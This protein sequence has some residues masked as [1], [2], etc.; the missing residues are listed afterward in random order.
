M[1]DELDKNWKDHLAMVTKLAG[2]LMPVIGGPLSELIV[3]TI[4]R[5]RQERIVEY[6]RLLDERVIKLE[7]TSIAVVL[8]DE[9]RIDLVETGGHLAAR[10]TSFDRIAMI[11]EIVGRGLC[12][13]DARFIRRKRRLERR[14]DLFGEIDDDEFSIL[15]A[16]GQSVGRLRSDK[17]DQID[18]PAPAM[19]GSSPE[20]ID[21]RKLYEAGIQKLLRL[22][23]LEPQF[24]RV[25]KGEYPPFDPKAGGFKSRPKVSYLGRMLLR[26]AGVE[27]PW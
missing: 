4:P 3:Q 17:W 20:K 25:K 19:L 1:S 5:L 11:A 26:E 22:G 16:F 9:E 14:L 27:L 6:L 24:D 8:A 12:S 7:Q 2:A 15:A 23:L 18:R 21:D 13:E 10:A